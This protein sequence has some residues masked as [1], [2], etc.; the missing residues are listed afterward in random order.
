[1]DERLK[2]L[3]QQAGEQR[4]TDN[5]PLHLWHPPLSGDIPIVISAD[6][7]W[8]HDGGEIKRTALVKLFASIL[9]REE[10]GEYYLVT[11][12]EKWRIEVERHPL[13]VTDVEQSTDRPTAL[14]VTL[15]TGR[16]VVVDAQHP[17]FLDPA[18]DGIAAIAL[19]HGLSALFT[20]A[21]WY[22]LVDM[23][24]ERDGVPLVS[25][26]GEDYPLI[27]R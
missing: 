6:G 12:V 25:S 11:P 9:R 8:Y 10:A 22:R 26:C 20:R 15:N 7:T 18:V 4:D 3:E 24:V 13:M 21:A 14:T 23:A 27:V 17:L 1:M 5:P 19:D 2:S 16:Q